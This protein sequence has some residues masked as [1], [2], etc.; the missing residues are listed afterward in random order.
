M[1][2]SK[3]EL[4]RRQGFDRT[5]YNPKEKTWT[6]RCSQ[7]EVVVINNVACHEQGCPNEVKDEED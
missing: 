6:P 1:R 2:V 3:T 5:K 7:C 4:L